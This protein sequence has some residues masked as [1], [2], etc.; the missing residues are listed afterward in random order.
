[1]TFHISDVK[2]FNMPK[3]IIETRKGDLKII[4]RD[5][6]LELAKYA[7]EHP[8]V[9]LDPDDYS[10]FSQDAMKYVEKHY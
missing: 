7:K 8:E 1:M 3:R 9:D 6:I 10:K 5:I 4:E 2:N